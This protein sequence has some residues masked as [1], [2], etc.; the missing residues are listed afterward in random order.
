MIK[1]VR[2]SYKAV[3]AVLLL[4]LFMAGVVFQSCTKE[5]NE[6]RVTAYGPAKVER[7]GE[8]CF[9]GH[10]LDEVERISLPAD[11]YGEKWIIEKSDFISQ[12]SG[13]ITIKIPCDYPLDVTGQVKLYYG[14]GKEYVT[15]SRFMVLS[16]ATPLQVIVDGKIYVDEVLDP[17]T[18]LVTILG[19]VLLAADSIIFKDIEGAGLGVSDFIEHTD[20]Y[21]KFAFPANVPNGSLMQLKV[22]ARNESMIDAYHDL[23]EVF[24]VGPSVKGF[25]PDG[26]DKV[27]LCGKLEILVNRIDRI[28]P[29]DI[30][31]EGYTQIIIG[32]LETKGKVDVDGGKIIFEPL[33][34]ML[35]FYEKH[36]SVTLTS[37]GQNYISETSGFTIAK[38]VFNTVLEHL[39][40][41]NYRIY[42]TGDNL[43]T[44]RALRF[45]NRSGNDT[46]GTSRLEE[47]GWS[48]SL[49][50]F[51]ISK[52]KIRLIFYSGD[53]IEFDI[54]D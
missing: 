10:K 51:D 36:T 8:I 33:P 39:S 37:L 52:T 15:M 47:N 32:T 41:N 29:I 22:P 14:G 31:D 12:S 7:C 21:I 4:C 50:N 28:R 44:L 35:S 48:F 6:F 53:E 42:L 18:T 34:N 24:V 43:C 5:D 54:N 45:I 30:D 26:G 1:I 46:G 23:C 20:Q 19:K 49:V 27:P 25:A 9:K 2:K 38:P 17:A 3:V 40:G 13:E 11:E 16:L